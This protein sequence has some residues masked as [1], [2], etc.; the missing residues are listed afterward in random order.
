[1]NIVNGTIMWLTFRQLFERKRLIASILLALAPAIIALLFRMNG[2]A[3][4]TP[5]DRF[6][7]EMYGAFVVGVLLPL[8]A[9]VFGTGAF[10]IDLDEGTIIYLLVKPLRRWTVVLSRYLVA[11]LATMAV[12]LPAIILP[13]LVIGVRVLPPSTVLAVAIGAAVGALLYAA[14][15]LP[16]GIVSK[17]ALVIGLLYVVVLEEVVSRSIDGA[18]S[19]SIRE[20]AYAIM[21]ASTRGHD[22]F[23]APALSLSTVWVMGTLVLVAGLAIAMR[24]L[25]RFQAEERL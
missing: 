14:L 11:V 17:R 1:M 12:M 3:L 7:A 6:L 2:N 22:P 15:F 24:K 9:V 21:K 13:W 19:L 16:L 8:A 18:R 25:A 5:P 10:G 4:G 23:P 20:F